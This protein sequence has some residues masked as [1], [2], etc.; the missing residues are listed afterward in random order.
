MDILHNLKIFNVNKYWFVD[1]LISYQSEY[2]LRTIDKSYTVLL[3]VLIECLIGC[4]IINIIG[5]LV[6]YLGIRIF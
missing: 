3:D 6:A 1:I 2:L 5:N 4:L